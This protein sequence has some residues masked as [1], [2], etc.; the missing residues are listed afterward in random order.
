[1]IAK[2]SHVAHHP[3]K[4]AR[5]ILIYEKLEIKDAIAICN[6]DGFWM[7]LGGLLNTRLIF[8]SRRLSH[9]VL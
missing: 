5:M 6:V 9:L 2:N 7:M 3:D 4:S 1:L 8:S